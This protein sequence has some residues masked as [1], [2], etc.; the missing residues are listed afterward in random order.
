MCLGPEIALVAQVIGAAATVGGTAYGAVQTSQASAAS[1]KAEQLRK[2][3]MELELSQKRRAAIRQFQQ[4]RANAAANIQGATGSL[5]GSA[6]GGAVGGYTST[7]GTQLGEYSQA[8]AIGSG[9][10]DANA[11][12][13]EASAGASFGS[14]VSSFGKDL[15]QSGP[16][17]GRIGA[18]LFNGGNNNA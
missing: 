7:L 17:I 5:E 4:Q 2:R 9:I 18:T 10:F 6:F 12:Y 14:A 13:S 11:A 1:K 3:Q 8:G 16:A 15:F